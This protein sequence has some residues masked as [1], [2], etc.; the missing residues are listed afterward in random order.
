MVLGWLGL[1]LSGLLLVSRDAVV[2]AIPAGFPAS[3]NGLWYDQPAVNWSTQ[4]LPIG[5][6]Y[7]GAMVNGNPVSDRLQLNIE[8][9]WSGGPFQDPVRVAQFD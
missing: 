7:L 3:G 4:F 6:G 5:N 9:L 2:G 1:G 8:S